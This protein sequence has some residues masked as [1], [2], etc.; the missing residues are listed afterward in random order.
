MRIK[1]KEIQI[2]L[3]CLIVWFIVQFVYSKFV[4]SLGDQDKYL[5]GGGAR[6]MQFFSNT[7][8]TVK[9][10]EFIKIFLPWRFAPLLPLTF[11]A[12]FLYRSFKIFY[13]KLTKNERIILLLSASLPHF[14]IWQA[15]AS[16]E[17]IVVPCGLI[18]GYY[19]SKNIFFEISIKESPSSLTNLKFLIQSLVS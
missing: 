15:V 11:T 18:F 12:I 13:F 16:K 1:K 5:F 17:A 3:L 2:F 7:F 8:I 6:N 19:F 9:I 14:W 4:G 10:Y